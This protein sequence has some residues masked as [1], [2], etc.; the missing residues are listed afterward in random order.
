MVEIPDPTTYTP[1]VPVLCSSP[2]K[3]GA[4]RAWM[5]DVAYTNASAGDNIVSSKTN[6]E[7]SIDNGVTW[8]STTKL[9][10]GLTGSGTL[11]GMIVRFTPEYVGDSPGVISFVE[12]VIP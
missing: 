6:T 11:S 4:Y 5:L 2:V 1:S 7:F 9:V 8:Y 3:V 10:H 12:A